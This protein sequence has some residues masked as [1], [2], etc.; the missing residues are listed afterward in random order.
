M[1]GRNVKILKQFAL[2]PLF[3]MPYVH[4]DVYHDYQ[5]IWG[6]LSE[7]ISPNE[8]EIEF[9]K[10][11]VKYRTAIKLDVLLVAENEKCDRGRGLSLCDYLETSLTGKRIGLVVEGLYSNV[12]AGDII[13]DE[14]S[15]TLKALKDGYYRFDPKVSRALPYVY[16]EKEARC[17]FKG[18]W[19]NLKGDPYVAKQC[20]GI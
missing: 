16:A 14:Q 8:V 3:F 18:L 4:S 19:S 11:G 15:L 20:Q 13:V 7:V 12:V 2:I 10:E 9:V 6:E 17:S 5:S 1:K